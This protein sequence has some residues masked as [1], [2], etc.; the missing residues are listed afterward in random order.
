MK[1]E[2]GNGVGASRPGGE[3]NQMPFTLRENRDLLKQKGRK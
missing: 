1:R 2:R 3:K